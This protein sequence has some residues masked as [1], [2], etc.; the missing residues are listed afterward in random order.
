MAGH[1]VDVMDDAPDEKPADI[2]QV[3]DMVKICLMTS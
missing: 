3:V 2:E 1:V